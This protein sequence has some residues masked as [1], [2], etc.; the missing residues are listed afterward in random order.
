[1]SVIGAM[2]VMCVICGV[3][4][5]FDRFVIFVLKVLCVV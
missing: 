2:F 4:V 1:M 3:L 5:M